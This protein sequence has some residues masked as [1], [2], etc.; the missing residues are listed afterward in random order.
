MTWIIIEY[1]FCDPPKVVEII[2]S[3]STILG[4][5][6]IVDFERFREEL[7]DRQ[8]TK[9]TKTPEYYWFSAT[10]PPNFHRT[11]YFLREVGF[12]NG[13]FMSGTTYWFE[14]LVVGITGHTLKSEEL[15]AWRAKRRSE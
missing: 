8:P 1:N 12:S 9:I 5:I 6:P 4:E 10:D 7:I 15:R 14:P 2:D 13:V 3:I 11:S